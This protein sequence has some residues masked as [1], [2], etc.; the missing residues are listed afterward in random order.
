MKSLDKFI[1]L[2]ILLGVALFTIYSIQRGEGIEEYTSRIQKKRK[3]ID[4]F[5][6]YA[7]NSPFTGDMRGAFK[8]LNYFPPDPRYKVVANLILIEGKETI[9]IP[10]S[11]GS[12]DRYN[13]YAFV[14]L[15]LDGSS[16]RLLLLKP[17]NSPVANR[18]FLAFADETSGNET[19]GGGRYIDL[20]QQDEEKIEIDFNLAYNPYCVYNLNYS[21][22]IPPAENRLPIEILAGEKIY[23]IY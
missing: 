12:I 20:Y 13:R 16:Y 4:D 23:K 2:A 7:E 21:C 8:G 15:T 9:F 5:M 11:D 14:E 19:Y 10:T 3:E 6:R 1:Y 18:L 17:E 22:P